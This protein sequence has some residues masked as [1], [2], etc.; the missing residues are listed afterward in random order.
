MA[1]KI[2]QLLSG[3]D[4]STSS[5]AVVED[6]AGSKSAAPAKAAK[7]A[8]S[9]AAPT[10][11]SASSSSSNNY[12]AKKATT[13]TNSASTSTAA[14]NAANT[15]KKSSNEEDTVEDLTLSPEQAKETLEGLG[16][17]NWG[18]VSAGTEG[19]IHLLMAS[20]KWQEK[21][22]VLTILENKLIELKNV[23]GQYSAALVCYLASQTGGFKISNINI[24]K[25]VI[26]VAVAAAQNCGQEKF[27]RPAGKFP[28]KVL[29][30]FFVIYRIFSVI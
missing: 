28:S 5:A 19:S 1:K 23:G 21:V 18:S 3:G 17:D 25:G 14:N 12:A 30:I 4:C 9:K 24:L 6:E 29:R 20:S 22:E 13:K 7:A 11:A 10:S 26:A 16:I 27:S 2:Q 15:S 8:P